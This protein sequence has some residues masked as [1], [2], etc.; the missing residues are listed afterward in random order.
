MKVERSAKPDARYKIVCTDGYTDVP[1]LIVEADE[2]AGTF[3]LME[4]A[5]DKEGR[6]IVNDS[7]V[8]QYAEKSYEWLPGLFKIIPR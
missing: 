7:G 8:G 6:R 1:G 2:D 4:P 5:Y 3:T